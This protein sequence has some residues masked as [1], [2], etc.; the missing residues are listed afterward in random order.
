MANLSIVV[1]SLNVQME[2]HRQPSD[3]RYAVACHKLE[4]TTLLCY[5]LA[6]LV[7]SDGTAGAFT[8][9]R[10]VGEKTK[11]GG[12]IPR[13]PTEMRKL[14]PQQHPKKVRA[15]VQTG[16]KAGTALSQ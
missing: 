4:S 6:P 10:S 12:Q 1:T 5:L 2:I 14:M 8:A 3:R 9:D 7:L 16:R 11:S 15:R 13:R